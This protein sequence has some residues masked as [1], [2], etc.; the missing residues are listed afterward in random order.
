MAFDWHGFVNQRSIHYVESGSNVARGNINVHCPF[1]GSS[2]TSEHMGLNISS[3]AW[4]C[5][6]SDEHRGRRPHRLIMALLRCSYGEAKA[7]V[8]AG[9]GPLVAMEELRKRAHALGTRTHTVTRVEPEPVTLPPD[10][11][12]ITKLGGYARFYRYVQ[13]RGFD[14]VDVPRVC[15][16]YQLHG[17]LTGAYKY[18]L[19]MPIVHKKRWVGWTGRHIGAAKPKYL[20]HPDGAGLNGVLYN[21]DVLRVGGRVLVLV[22]GPLD[23]LKLDYYGKPH[24]VRA[25][26]IR[27][28]TASDQ[29][30]QWVR[31]HRELWDRVVVVLDKGAYRNASRIAANLLVGAKPVLVPDPY[32]DP[33]AMPPQAV[34]NFAKRLVR[35]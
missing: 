25:V 13:S 12:T 18:R 9:G 28:V 29:Q 1:C 15:R 21:G 31:N 19:I 17:C 8:E 33:G 34:V 30:L 14:Y 7:L 5:W 10:F 2:D 3:G 35:G 27:T 24:G 6:R 16:R 26:A 22:E 32:D 23:A 20:T 4:G 11:R